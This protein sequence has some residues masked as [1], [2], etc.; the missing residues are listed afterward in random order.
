[1]EN[2]NENENFEKIHYILIGNC[3]NNQ[4]IVEHPKGSKVLI[5]F[6]EISIDAMKIFEN[7]KNTEY[8]KVDEKLKVLTQNGQFFFTLTNSRIFYLVFAQ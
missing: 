8:Y 1:M 2:E 7:L 5:Y 3:Y 6:I 4:I